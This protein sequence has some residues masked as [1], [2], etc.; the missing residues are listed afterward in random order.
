MRVI[1]KLIFYNDKGC[2]GIDPEVPFYTLNW[3]R[4]H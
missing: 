2:M 3:A 1:L 4:K